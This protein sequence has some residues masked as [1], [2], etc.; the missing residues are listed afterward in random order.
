MA[1]PTLYGRRVEVRIAGL[2]IR[3][4]H[5]SFE[6]KRQADKTE[7]KGHVKIYNLTRQHEQQI[8]DRGEAIRLDA[9]Y[10]ETIAVLFDG[11]VQRVERR[12]RRLARITRI[13]LGGHLQAADRVGGYTNRSYAGS[14]SI[15]RI[16]RDIV[17]RDIGLGIGPLD[18]IPADAQTENY[19][20]AGSSGL[21]LDH[22][23]RRVGVTFIE[24]DG[25]IKFNKPGAAASDGVSLVLSPT[26]GLVGA[27][28]VTDD[29]VECESLLQPL[30]RVGGLLRLRAET[31]SGTFKIVGVKH[32]GDNW[33]GDYRTAYDL[34]PVDVAPPLR[35]PGA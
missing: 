19:A 11:S 33:Q 2:I 7:P 4:L 31:Y 6:V 24:D 9:G 12:R 28:A 10:P 32:T 18:A 27:P 1:S 15:R 20:W 34:R 23:L 22:L 29:G 21:A 14:E 16:A 30:A 26:S 13:E 17:E 8:E 5:I 25:V 35:F 3:D